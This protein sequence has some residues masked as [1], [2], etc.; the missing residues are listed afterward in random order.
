MSFFLSKQ[1]YPV[2]P[3]ERGGSLLLTMNALGWLSVSISL[4]VSF[5]LSSK[6]VFPPT[7]TALWLSA[8]FFRIF[9]V[10]FLD[11]EPETL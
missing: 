5:G 8:M 2:L 10:I 9:I 11:S 3:P 6:K 4:T 1:K 7:M